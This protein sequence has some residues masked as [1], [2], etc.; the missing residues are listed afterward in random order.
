[1]RKTLFV[2]LGCAMLFTYWACNKNSNAVGPVNFTLADSSDYYPMAVGDQWTV[3]LWRDSNGV[4][5]PGSDATSPTGFINVKT[6]G[7]RTAYGYGIPGYDSAIAYYALDAQGNQLMFYDTS[8][9]KGKG[10]WVINTELSNTVKGRSSQIFIPIIFGI[11]GNGGGPFDTIRSIDTMIETY[12]GDTVITVPSGTYAAEY[13]RDSSGTSSTYA[14]EQ[15]FYAKGIGLIKQVNQ[16]IFSAPP[17][18]YSE[19]GQYEELVS[20]S[21]H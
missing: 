10:A 15:K 9:G 12:M 8:F 16:N 7:G 4:K 1:M 11:G 14:I 19:L 3:H 17:Y 20:Y 5:T 13:Y 21:V 6:I 18:Y 2:L